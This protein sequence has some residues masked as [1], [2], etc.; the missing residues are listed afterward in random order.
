MK[1]GF[2]KYYIS[3]DVVT[4]S[5]DFFTNKNGMNDK[6]I[7]MWL[8]V[9][10]YFKSEK[11]VI[12]YDIINEPTGGNFWAN[13]YSFLGPD[14]DNNRILLPFYKKASQKIRE[15]EKDRLLLFEP[16]PQDMIGGFYQPFSS[17]KS[18]DLLNYHTYCPFALGTLKCQLYN[19]IYT[20][21]RQ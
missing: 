4:F 17:F 5:H 18:K 6:F 21:R 13:P 9:V 11:N 16:A 20:K 14:Q 2:F 1:I 7:E 8:K 3:Y 12:G 15:I 10:E 19:S